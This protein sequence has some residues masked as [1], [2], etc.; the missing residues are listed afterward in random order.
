MIA[1]KLLQN[2]GE[3]LNNCM[4]SFAFFFFLHSNH[5]IL[6]DTVCTV[7]VPPDLKWVLS[8]ADEQTPFWRKHGGEQEGKLKGG[9]S[10]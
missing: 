6:L 10:F 4:E 1:I 7:L 8:G 2:S 9:G 3:L 5:L